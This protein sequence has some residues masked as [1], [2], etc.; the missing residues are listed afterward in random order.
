M[1]RT[2]RKISVYRKKLLYNELLFNELKNC[3]VHVVASYQWTKSSE[4]FSLSFDDAKQINVNINLNC[5][6]EEVLL[7]HSSEAIIRYRA[8]FI[9]YYIHCIETAKNYNPQDYFSGLVNLEAI[10]CHFQKSVKVYSPLSKKT[11]TLRPIDF[12]CAIRALTRL[13]IEGDECFPIEIKKGCED[14]INTF[15]LYS[16]LPEI[17]L[18]RKR[19]KYSLLKTFQMVQRLA[20]KE[21]LCLKDWAIFEKNNMVSFDEMTAKEF[22]DACEHSSN[23]FW[24]GAAIRFIALAKNEVGNITV[25]NKPNINLCIS[26]FYEASVRYYKEQT[27]LPDGVIAKNY[28]AIQKTSQCIEQVFDGVTITNGAVHYIH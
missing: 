18:E 28:T 3:S 26:E 15:L 24:A 25:I 16:G 14:K 12:Y 7:C 1:K 13:I 17:E 2:K 4:V 23:P 10:C 19:A 20:Q 9:S 27:G 6:D 5:T 11:T 22:L 21:K 8:Y